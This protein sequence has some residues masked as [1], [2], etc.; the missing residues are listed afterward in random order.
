MNFDSADV[1]VMTT[2][3]FCSL[4]VVVM[5]FFGVIS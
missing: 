2:C 1:V 5:Y 3:L 4:S